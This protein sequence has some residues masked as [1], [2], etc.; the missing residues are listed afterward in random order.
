MGL[1]E[2]AQQ[3][4][5][6]PVIPHYFAR[7]LDQL[8]AGTDLTCGCRNSNIWT[9]RYLTMTARLRNHIGSFTHG[10]MCH[11][12]ASSVIVAKKQKGKRKY[13]H[14]PAAN[15]ISMCG[16]VDLSMLLWDLLTS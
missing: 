8:A 7:V 16:Y 12:S 2:L 4:R 14:T 10:S 15:L 5:R 9:A 6:N 13:C 3:F 1:D 11:A